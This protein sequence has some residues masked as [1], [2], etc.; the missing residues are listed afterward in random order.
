MHNNVQR[1]YGIP[2]SK[3]L[4]TLS[5]FSSMLLKKGWYAFFSLA[6]AAMQESKA[7]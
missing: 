2:N 1:E 4:G 6:I 3:D 7:L 5:Y